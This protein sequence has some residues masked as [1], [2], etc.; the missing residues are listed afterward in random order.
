MRVP[1]WIS[2]P[3]VGAPD[4]GGGG[5]STADAGERALI[6]DGAEKSKTTVSAADALA[7][8][9]DREAALPPGAG[10]AASQA[11]AGVPATGVDGT[12]KAGV[13]S[14]PAGAG[15]PPAPGVNLGVPPSQAAQGATGT[16]AGGGGGSA[17]GVG[18][19]NG[20]REYAKGFGFP[21]DQFQSDNDYAA[22]LFRALQQGQA[23]LTDAERYRQNRDVIERTLAG[24]APGVGGA[25]APVAPEK[26]KSL[27]EQKPPFDPRWLQMVEKDPV[28]GQL[29]A[30][31][32][33]DPNVVAS[34]GK[35]Q[36]WRE[37]FSDELID[38]GPAAFGDF[39]SNQV[40]QAVQQAMQAT[41]RDQAVQSLIHQNE[42]W[43][44]Q[45]NPQ[46]QFV[47]G[48]DGRR[49]VSPAGQLYMSELNNLERAGITDP[50]VSHDLA[51]QLVKGKIAM[52]QAAQGQAQGQDDAAK[53]AALAGINPVNPPNRN[54]MGL[55]SGVNGSNGTVAADRG[56]EGLSLRDSLAAALREVPE[57]SMKASFVSGRF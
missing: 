40:N 4:G 1:Y 41:Q 11:A 25:A 50:K 2:D 49:I 19:I 36:A 43:V 24:G 3:W 23:A 7:A 35:Y 22:A 44:Y 32:G 26:P 37:Q 42:S 17:G 53:K 16:P 33:Y 8:Q 47:I 27:W 28:T 20:L 45:Q 5:G 13:A 46:G 15:A 57:D 39:F 18:G 10:A 6:S 14:P 48:F 30:K 21:V 12:S 29:R 54:G 38:K 31:Q 55:T 52:A 34:I 9:M 51:L 56:G